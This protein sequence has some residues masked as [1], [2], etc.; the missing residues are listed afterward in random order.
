MPA[1]KK[2]EVFGPEDDPAVTEPL[3]HSIYSGKGT[4]F[5]ENLDSHVLTQESSIS[6]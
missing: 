1:D 6:R 3:P 2:P 5:P 4:N